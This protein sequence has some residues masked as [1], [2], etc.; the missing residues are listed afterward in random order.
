[1]ALLFIDSFDHYAF[2]DLGLKWTSAGGTSIATGR[3]GSCLQGANYACSKSFT[4]AA[5]IVVGFALKWS[6]TAAGGTVCE[7]RNGTTVHAQVRLDNSG[8]LVAANSGGTPYTGGTGTAVLSAGVWYYVEAKVFVHDTTGTFDVKLNGAS[9]LALTGLD[10]RNGATTTI[11]TIRIGNTGTA[12]A[13][14]DDLYILDTSGSAPTNDFLGDC[15]VEAIFP[16]GAGNYAQWT[17]LSSTNVSNVDETTP[18][19]DTTYNSSS[20]ANQIDSFAYG[21]LTPSSATVYGLQY[22]L[23]ARKDDAGTRTIAPLARISS[24]DYASATTHNLSTS[25]AYYLQI[26]EQSPASS[27]AWTVSEING[28]EFGYK[29]IA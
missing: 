26:K 21:N 23:Y 22:A 10:T 12:T 27:S 29:E 20:T 4:G 19:G 6:N 7:L 2:A 9:E 17:P 18:D 5:T 1:M 15:R 24:T 11:D 13:S 14:Y 25:Y 28:A 8:H 16:T 3:F